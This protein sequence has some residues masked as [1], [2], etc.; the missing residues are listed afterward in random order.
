MRRKRF[1]LGAVAVG[2]VLPLGFAATPAGATTAIYPQFSRSVPSVPVACTT[3][4]SIPP[5]PDPHVQS[6]ERS[7]SALAGTHLQGI[8]QCGNGLLVLT[9]TAGS[10]SV[11]QK[12]RAKFGPS[13]QIMV[14]LT[15]WNGRP[16]RSPRCGVLPTAST[17]SDGYA[18]TLELRAKRIVSGADLTGKVA[19]RATGNRTVRLD[20]NSP[21]S[22]VVTA[23]GTRRVVGV[24]AGAVAGTGLTR[25]VN[26]GQPQSVAIVGGTARCDGGVGSVLPPGRYNA[27]GLISGPGITGPIGQTGGPSAHFTNTV[28]IRVVGRR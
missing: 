12:V 22:V 9:L 23:P 11:A 1:A 18:S 8:G 25:L 16:G 6:I 24:F 20:A 3:R 10:E 13:V 17:M 21:I 7:V 14:G 5:V 26:P 28:P 4:T 15:A 2:A 19:V 27:V